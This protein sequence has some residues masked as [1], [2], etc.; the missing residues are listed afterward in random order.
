MKEIETDIEDRYR[1]VDWGYHLK[2]ARI[3]GGGSC[4]RLSE[5]NWEVGERKKNLNY[6]WFVKNV[7]KYPYIL[8][9]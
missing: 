3:C 9:T 7:I 2:D 4:G 6:F 1:F 5:V 8:K